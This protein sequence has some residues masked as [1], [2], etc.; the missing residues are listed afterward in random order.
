MR[1]FWG[2]ALALVML[3]LVPMRTLAS[4]DYAVNW[5]YGNGDYEAVEIAKMVYANLS[6]EEREIFLDSLNEGDEL[7]EFHKEFIDTSFD[8][9]QIVIVGRPNRGSKNPLLSL[10]A[11]IAALAIPVAMKYALNAMGVSLV[12]AVAEGAL[13]VG[14]VLLAA[15]AAAVATTAAIYWN[16]VEPKW[17]SIVSAFTKSFSRSKSSISSAFSS[18]KKD[19]ASNAKRL[20]KRVAISISGKDVYVKDTKYLC[21]TK[22]DAMSKKQIEKGYYFVALVYRNQ[23]YI[24]A[25]H[26]VSFNVAKSVIMLNDGKV[27]I[28]ATSQNKA[29]GV[30]SGPKAIFHDKHKGDGGYYYHYHHP[31]YKDAHCWFLNLSLK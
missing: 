2:L 21:K 12:G 19:A 28:W 30:C 23:I 27:G 9:S 1:G 10:R 6:A 16:K 29:K 20:K 8:K 26:P 31:Q 15:S 25:D 4:G 17:G 24:D 11:A 18:I 14:K 7:Y 3:L 13:P 5:Y 22:A